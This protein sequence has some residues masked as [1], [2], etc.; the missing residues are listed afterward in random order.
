MFVFVD[1][2]SS[3]VSVGSVF[4][5]V[6]IVDVEGMIVGL[7][8]IFFWRTLSFVDVGGGVAASFCIFS[9]ICKSGVNGWFSIDWMVEIWCC[10][11]VG[12]L[13]YVFEIVLCVVVLSMF[14]LITGERSSVGYV[15]GGRFGCTSC[16]AS[17]L[18]CVLVNNLICVG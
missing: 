16:I 5:I 13:E 15:F 9:S 17:S 18:L 3:K 10:K 14:I 8:F 7:V 2:L 6:V 11:F 12:V 4:F 1:V